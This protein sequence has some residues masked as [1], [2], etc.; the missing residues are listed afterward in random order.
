MQHFAVTIEQNEGTPAS[1]PSTSPTIAAEVWQ[2]IESHIAWRFTPR[3]V[4]WIVEGPGL[5]KSPLVPT[6]D[7][8]VQVW[9]DDTKAYE[10]VT[11]EASAFDGY[12]FRGRG[13][14]KIQA[15]VGNAQLP[16]IV[17][18]AAARLAAYM[19][20]KPGNGSSQERI[21]AGSIRLWRTREASWMAKAI[22]N[23]GAA[24][25]LRNYRRA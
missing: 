14:Y 4:V 18:T 7:A 12:I 5:W 13:P 11:P 16:A 1:Y 9:N 2:R 6:V 20:L 8:T 17:A 21:E 23:S 19:A 15:T 24:D 10:D 3:S 25:L 22:Q